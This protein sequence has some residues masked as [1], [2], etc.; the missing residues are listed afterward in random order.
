MRTQRRFGPLVR[1]G[2]AIG[3]LGL[4]AL[5][6]AAAAPPP[7]TLDTSWGAG[8]G[9]VIGSPSYPGV[10]G[11]VMQGSKVVVVGGDVGTNNGDFVVSRYKKD[12]SPDTSFGGTGTVETDF[13]GRVDLASGVALQGTKIVVV[14]FTCSDDSFAECQFAVARYLKNGTLDSSFNGT[15]QVMTNFGDDQD[16]ADAVLVKSN[17]ITV[18]GY[19][20]GD[21]ALAQYQ[22]NGALNTA[23]DSDGLVTTDFDGGFDAAN[24]IASQGSFLVVAGY[25]NYPDSDFALARYESDGDLDTAFGGGTGKVETDF[26]GG[27][28]AGHSVDVKGKSIVVVGSATVGHQQFAAARYDKNGSLDPSFN[29]TGTATMDVGTDAVAFDGTLAGGKVVAVG[30]TCFSCLPGNEFGVARWNSNGTPDSGFGTNGFVTTQVDGDDS[31]ASAVAIVS[32]KI[33][34]GGYSDDFFAIA[35]YVG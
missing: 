23:F 19:A 11:L 8:T 28:D 12:G 33:V 21:F 14:G 1:A 22:N 25:A 17:K 5:P 10:Q 16:F 13:G 3:L 24:A 34:V 6:A 2:L 31:G 15:G 7:G 26:D 30:Q 29:G 9:Y 20:S 32:G 27:A 35:R 4:F 18:A